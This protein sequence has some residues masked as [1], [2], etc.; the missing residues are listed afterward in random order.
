M[1]RAQEEQAL[2]LGREHVKRPYRNMVDAARTIVME[3]GVSA[4]YKYKGAICLSA[5]KIAFSH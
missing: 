3:E 4:L 2:K 1:K 5:K